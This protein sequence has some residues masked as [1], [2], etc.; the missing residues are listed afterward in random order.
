MVPAL[1]DLQSRS[2]I[3]RFLIF[4]G[5]NI[6]QILSIESVPALRDLQSRSS[7]GRFPIFK[8]NKITQI[9]PIESV[10]SYPNRNLQHCFSNIPLPFRQVQP[11][12]VLMDVIGL[13][14]EKLLE[15]TSSH[16]IHPPKTKF[17]FDDPKPRQAKPFYFPLDYPEWP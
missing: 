3:G 4:K 7:I 10:L 1:R 5:N 15:N 6:T 9:L 16:D 17:D 11:N 12:W 14:I 2:S 13:H 8:G